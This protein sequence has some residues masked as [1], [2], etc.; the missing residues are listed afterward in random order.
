MPAA[1][2]E[3]PGRGWWKQIIISHQFSICAWFE[4][5][6][7]LLLLLLLLLFVFVVGVAAAVVAFWSF[8]IPY[9]LSY[10]V[11]IFSKSYSRSRKYIQ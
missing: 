8:C 7:L 4:E 6:T 11:I 10:P 1:V 3:E 2:Q 5:K 9:E